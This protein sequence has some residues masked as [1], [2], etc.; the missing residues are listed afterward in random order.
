MGDKDFSEGDEV[1]FRIE[2]LYSQGKKFKVEILKMTDRGLQLY[3]SYND[4]KE[5][6]EIRIGSLP[7]GNYYLRVLNDKNEILAQENFTYASYSKE[8]RE[9]LPDAREIKNISSLSHKFVTISLKELEGKDINDFLDED[10]LY[11]KVKVG[12]KRMWHNTALFLI[13]FT[14]MCL[15]WGIRR[16]NGFS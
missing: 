9:I 12:E 13:L 11:E 16:K 5:N 3:A 10:V 14:A 2:P 15:E 8:V 1:F 6:E 7:R 4:V